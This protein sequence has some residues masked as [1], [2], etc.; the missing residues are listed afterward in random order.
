MDGGEQYFNFNGIDKQYYYRTKDLEHIGAYGNEVK[1]ENRPM[2]QRW[3]IDQCKN[4]IEEFGIDGFRIDLAGQID[5][6]TL[7]ALKEAIGEDKIVYGE[8]WIGSN[9]PEFENNPDWDWYKEDSPI[10]FFQDDARNAFKGPVFTLSD[11]YQDRGWPGGKFDERENVMKGLANRFDSD[12]TPISGI[13]YLDIHDNFALADQFAEADFDGRLAVDQDAYRIAATLLYTSLGPIVTHGGSEIMRSKAHAPL[14]EVVKT[15]NAGFKVY[16]HGYR[17]TYNHRTA[18]Q[19]IW[20]QVGKRPTATNRND[21]AMMQKFWKG[22]NEFRSSSYG[23]VFRVDSASEDYYQ[24]ILPEN[25]GQLGYVVDDRVLVLLNPS[26]V[27]G[28][29]DTPMLKE[30]LWQLVGTNQGISLRGMKHARLPQRL[31]GGQG[32]SINLNPGD[33]AIWVKN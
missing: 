19:F 7:I 23:E 31:Y 5:Q 26:K 33:I 12:K 10:T 3:L 29:F 28:Y 16:M 22:L 24:F 21:Y 13:N 14:Q 27:Q 15:T 8:A 32:Y 6:Q 20:E 4:Y 25:E 17:D 2:V 1:T 9:D 30:G 11:K 18:N